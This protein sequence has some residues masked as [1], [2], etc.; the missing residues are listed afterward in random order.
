[1]LKPVITASMLRGKTINSSSTIYA[2]CGP[3]TCSP[4][5]HQGLLLYATGGKCQA[6]TKPGCPI[7]AGSP[8]TYLLS[9]LSSLIFFSIFSQ[10]KRRTMIVHDIKNYSKPFFLQRCCFQNPTTS[11]NCRNLGNL[12]HLY[13]LPQTFMHEP[14]YTSFQSHIL[15]DSL[16]VPSAY[17]QAIPGSNVNNIVLLIR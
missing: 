3:R 8:S 2:E 15:H 7:T 5:S 11:N 6:R 17:L 1:M 13:V 16:F 4:S 10:Y 9:L 14:K 12:Y